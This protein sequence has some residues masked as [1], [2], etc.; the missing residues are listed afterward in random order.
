V[1]PVDP[2]PRVFQQTL[3]LDAIAAFLMDGQATSRLPLSRLRGVSRAWREHFSEDAYWKLV[4]A[5]L[6]PAMGVGGKGLLSEQD[7]SYHGFLVQHGRGL[8]QGGSWW[9]D[10]GGYVGR[11]EMHVEIW[12]AHAGFRIFS[13][14]CPAELHFLDPPGPDDD[15]LPLLFGQE[16]ARL[17][18]AKKGPTMST[19]FSARSMG[20]SCI[21]DYLN[22][23]SP[24]PCTQRAK[25][26]VRNCTTGKSALVWR[27]NPLGDAWSLIE[28]SSY[29]QEG[30]WED[31]RHVHVTQWRPEW[32]DA[33]RNV[34]LCIGFGRER[35]QRELDP[36]DQIWKA[37]WASV[38]LEG[39]ECIREFIQQLL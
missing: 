6:M 33:H 14:V 7:L 11:L 29:D 22:D 36:R 28:P 19:P 8:V 21:E 39:Q 18:F 26:V 23:A 35:D 37:D 3:L 5:D 17:E 27:S 15:P 1:A 13:A 12:D 38:L 10:V 24:P 34:S 32:L 4:V 9:A 20:Q 30:A 2:R 16:R 25:I 31:R